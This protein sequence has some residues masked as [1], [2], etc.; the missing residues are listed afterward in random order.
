MTLCQHIYSNLWPVMKGHSR[1]VCAT[2]R[3]LRQPANKKRRLPTFTWFTTSTFTTYTVISG[4]PLLS[5][6]FLKGRQF[7]CDG[8]CCCFSFSAMAKWCIIVAGILT[9]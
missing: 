4:A 1:F 6:L 2:W 9:A 3:Y 5:L 7:S 8:A